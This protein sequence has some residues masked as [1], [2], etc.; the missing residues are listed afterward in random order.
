MK[1]QE[2]KKRKEELAAANDLD[3]MILYLQKM[4]PLCQDLQELR[5]ILIEL[6]DLLFDRGKL[7]EAEKLYREYS[8]LYPSDEHAEYAHYKAILCCF[9]K[10]LDS[11]R[12]QTKTHET[13]ELAQQFL[14]RKSLFTKYSHEVEKI[15]VAC[16]ERLAQSELSI[17]AFYTKRG[18]YRSSEHR[19]NQFRKDW[20]EKTPQM[21]APF[22][23]QEYQLALAQDN[24]QVKAQKHKTLLEKFPAHPLTLTLGQQEIKKKP[25]IRRL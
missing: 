8:R 9:Y 2:L 1:Y 16:N 17:I 5:T 10:T 7:T 21:E 12:D 11:T 24:Q 14:E 22:I 13:I 6:A 25:V 15:V 20:I 23:Y 3:T 4:V 18:K 19:I